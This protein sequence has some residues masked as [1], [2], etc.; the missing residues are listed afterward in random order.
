MLWIPGSESHESAEAQ[1]GTL[2][3]VID[4]GVRVIAAPL[5][6]GTGLFGPRTYM[7]LSM[8]QGFRARSARQCSA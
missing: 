5:G 6:A 2:Q 8:A 1:S 3:G 7:R 4:D